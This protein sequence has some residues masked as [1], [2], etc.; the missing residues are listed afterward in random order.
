M[1]SSVRPSQ[2]PP[3]GVLIHCEKLRVGYGGR[4]ILPAIDLDVGAGEL[5]AIIGRNGNGK[6]TFFRT[7]LG[8]LSPVSGT[9]RRDPAMRVAY[10]PQRTQLDPIFPALA[11]EVVA[12]GCERGWSFVRPR[13]GVQRDVL[14]ALE[15]VGAGELSERPFREL[16]EGQK[17]RVL[18]ARTIAAKPSLALVDEPTS[19]MDEVAEREAFAH[20]DT[21]RREHGTTIMVVSHQ[22]GLLREVAAHALLL[23][24]SCGEV[25]CGSIGHVVAH[26]VFAHNFGGVAAHAHGSP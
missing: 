6:T 10:V 19:A 21:L 7:L 26:P 2:R 23:D 5:W 11:R 1:P 17:Q 13:L 9:L 4:A 18:L 12:M 15:Q 8:L 24:A 25:V 22:L 14:S 3:A 20:L 16:S